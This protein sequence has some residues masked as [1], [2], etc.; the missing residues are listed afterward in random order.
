MP[1]HDGAN[2]LW[3]DAPLHEAHLGPPWE[4]LPPEL[5]GRFPPWARGREALGAFVER[6]TW[7]S[8]EELRDA[9]RVAPFDPAPPCPR[10]FVSH[11]QPD[12]R[13][14][15]RIAYLSQ[16]HGFHFWVDVLDPGLQA[17]PRWKSSLTPQEYAVLTA[18]LIEMGLAN[19]THVCVAWTR[20]TP[21][22]AWV[23]YEYGRVADSG[24]R[25]HAAGAWV[26]STVP[27]PTL[28]EYMHLGPLEQTDA[29]VGA[30]LAGEHARY[31]GACPVPSLPPWTLPV[32]GPLP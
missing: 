8:L 9:L 5:P 10:L 3:T 18:G 16:Q 29:G 12:V 25:A 24:T 11:R 15:L 13:E 1:L 23:P 27:L 31:G 19:S 21:G 32:P 2:F 26:E 17:L 6:L 7:G 4:R 22:S 14:A 30:W 28:P 20:N